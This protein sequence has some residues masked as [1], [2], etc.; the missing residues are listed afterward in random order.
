MINTIKAGEKISD[1]HVL[2]RKV[3]KKTTKNGK[4]YY[5]LELS[6]NSGV[7]IGKIW[8]NVFSTCEFEIGKIIEIN[9]VSQEF[10]GKLSIIISSCVVINSE[11]VAEFRAN[12]PTLVFDIETIGKDF[13]ELDKEEQ[14]YLLN[15]LEK[16]TEDKKEAKGKTGLYSIFGKVCAI[17]GYDSNLGKGFALILGK[18]E[19]IPENENFKYHVFENEKDLLMKFWEIANKYE[20]FVTFNGTSFDFPYLVIRSGINRVKINY[21][22]KR[23]GNDH[24]DLMTKLNQNGRGYKLEM[25]CKAFGIKNPK[26]EG[27]HGDDVNKLF[28]A[29]EYNKIADYVSRDVVATNE[30]YLIWKEFLSGEI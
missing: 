10:G 15:N 4:P 30:L 8:D 18:G 19:I 16:N 3:D 22:M 6:D 7:I 13:D 11:E 17:G 24:V 28:K 26:E 27:I 25:L 9:G 5:E 14:D 1:L 20:L 2:V 12:I 21:E 23:Y 29:K